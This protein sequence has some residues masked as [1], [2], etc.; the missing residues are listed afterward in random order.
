MVAGLFPRISVAI[1]QA[2]QSGDVAGARRLNE[3]LQPLWSL[4]KE[5]SSL[6]VIYTSADVLGVCRA[7]PP[8][9]ILPLTG[10]ARQRVADVLKASGPA[11][12]EAGFSIFRRLA[13]NRI[14][15]QALDRRPAVEPTSGGQTVLTSGVPEC[16]SPRPDPPEQGR[17]AAGVKQPAGAESMSSRTLKTHRRDGGRRR[18]RPRR[19]RH[20]LGSDRHQGRGQYRQRPLGISEREGRDRRL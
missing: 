12:I 19:R 10:A 6:R 14:D 15:K 18:R 20:G 11:L 4:F 9:P 17:R 3:R 5:F 13:A 16:H 8:R 7:K 1:V 2:V